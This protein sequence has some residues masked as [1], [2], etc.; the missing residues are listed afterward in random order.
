MN[1]D[2]SLTILFSDYYQKM[3]GK[4]YIPYTVVVKEILIPMYER[5]VREGLPRIEDLPHEEKVSLTEECR[6]TGEKFTNE[7]LIKQCKILYLLRN[8]TKA[9]G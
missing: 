8:V 4:N 7:T 3:K 5:F 1:I 2:E 9:N 6:A